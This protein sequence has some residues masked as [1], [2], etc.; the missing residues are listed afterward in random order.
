M[1]RTLDGSSG[2]TDDPPMVRWG[3]L[4]LLQVSAG[5]V[6]LLLV[7]GLVVFGPDPI[8]IA[9]AVLMIAGVVLLRRRRVRPGAAVIILP[10]LVVLLLAAPSGFFI[11]PIR[12]RSMTSAARSSL[13][14]PCWPCSRSWPPLPR[15]SR[16]V[17]QV[18]ARQPSPPVWRSSQP[19]WRWWSLSPAASPTSA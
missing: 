2:L 18:S 17:C 9:L 10:S 4:R 15:S 14:C 13:S 1:A 19:W 16:D 5:L 12:L 8:F 3:W 6:I 7:I 11:A